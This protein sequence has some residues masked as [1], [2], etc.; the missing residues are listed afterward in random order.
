MN[1]EILDTPLRFELHGLS[2]EVEGD[3]MAKPDCG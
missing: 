1:L 2:S 3:A